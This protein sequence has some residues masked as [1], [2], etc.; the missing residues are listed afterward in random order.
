MT[1]ADR[2]ARD[3]SSGFGVRL[4]TLPISA[5]APLM[6]R[7]TYCLIRGSLCLVTALA[8]A[9][10]FGFRMAGGVLYTAAFVIVV[11][12]LTLGLSLGADATGT[13]FSNWE[14]ASQL[15]FI[16]QMLLMLLSTGFAPANAFPDWVQP[17][18]RNQ[19]LSQ[20]AETLRGL[21]GGNVGLG[22]AGVTLAWCVG[23]LT[24]FGALAVRMQRRPE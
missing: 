16:P 8:T 17:F 11:L 5:A 7:M 3:A 2:A 9:Y 14:A 10:V 22:N 23:L 4:G 12:A 18:V 19:P 1:T 13:R 21:A 15:L 20:I 24:V 6:A